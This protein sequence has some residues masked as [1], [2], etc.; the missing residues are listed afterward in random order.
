MQMQNGP[1]PAPPMATDKP[2]AQW[3]FSMLWMQAKQIYLLILGM[4]LLQKCKSPFI[5]RRILH[6]YL[7]W[8]LDNGVFV[9]LIPS[10]KGHLSDQLA[11]GEQ[12]NSNHAQPLVSR[13]HAI[14][15]THKLFHTK[16][17]CT[18]HCLISTM[19]IEKSLLGECA[20]PKIHVETVRFGK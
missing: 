13:F 16:I 19:A 15:N 9:F 10:E 17:F 2:T 8:C 20:L 6:H 1:L 11:F 14:A 3:R 12:L 7:K 4:T 5:V 18:L